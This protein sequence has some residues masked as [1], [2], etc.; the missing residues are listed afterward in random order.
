MN[1]QVDSTLD[2]TSIFFNALVEKTTITAKNRKHKT[3][4]P[5]CAIFVETAEGVL[6]HIFGVCALQT[7]TEHR[8]EHGEVDR[9]G[10]VIHHLVQ[11]L[12]RWVLAC[13]RQMK[14]G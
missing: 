7:L 1:Q 2:T 5:T 3:H 10:S 9:T 11:V 8:Q 14:V 13:Q 4:P 6:Y 12:F